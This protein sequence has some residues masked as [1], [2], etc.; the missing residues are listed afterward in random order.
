MIIWFWATSRFFRLL[1]FV[2]YWV[3]YIG[4]HKSRN[5]C[6]AAC[7]CSS[8]SPDGSGKHFKGHFITWSNCH[9]CGGLSKENKKQEGDTRILSWVNKYFSEESLPMIHIQPLITSCWVI[10]VPQIPFIPDSLD[11][12][13]CYA[14]PPFI[15]IKS[16]IWGNKE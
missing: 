5:I 16:K 3:R 4:S 6:Q 7:P 12:T 11:W 15:K 14:T 13:C 8:L 9:I 10:F 1:Y 2:T